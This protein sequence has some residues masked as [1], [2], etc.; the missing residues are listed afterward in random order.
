MR[1]WEQFLDEQE[2]ELGAETV[3]KWLRSLKILRYDARNLYLEAKDSFQIL[4]FEEHMRSKAYAKL[5]TGN[6]SR[7]KV[8][9]SIANAPE[10][11]KKEPKQKKG[12]ND[13][14][15][16]ELLFDTL[17]PHCTFNNFIADE[18][19]K[20]AH[21]LLLEIGTSQKR[22]SKENNA[23]AFNP[24]YL[25][26]HPGSGKTH[27]LMSLA[28]ALSAQGLKIIYTRANTFTDHVVSAIR[29]GQ[30]SQFRQAYRNIDVLIVDDIHVFSRKGATQ[31]EFFHTFNTL[32][33]ENKQIILSS[34]CSPQQLQYIEPRLVSRFEWGIVLP[35][36]SLKKEAMHL[37]LNS[38]AQVLQF[39]LPAHLAEFLV[40]TF[41][42]NSKS[43]IKALEAMVLRLHL[44]SSHQIQ[45]LSIPAV[46][47]L[48][49][50]LILEEQQRA[51]THAIII[52]VVAQ[53]YGIC[54]EDILSKGQRRDC[55]LPRQMAMY[56]CRHQLK[57]PYMKI[58]DIFSRDHSTVMSSIK[59]I[60]KALD[61]NDPEIPHTL[62]SIQK[63]L[64]FR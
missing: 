27:L 64:Q 52:Q 36:K 28:H 30:M 58:G 20:L 57:L 56:L 26:G 49:S 35:I 39:P 2:A 9:L 50:D 10:S 59:Q 45:N 24:I 7:I 43:L 21:Q 14:P 1:A 12:S 22:K 25:Y 32:H 40:E 18:E 3:Q 61:K 53:Q 60:Q 55:V 29:A 4:W 63:K 46:K 15:S 17:D 41:I 47:S 38:K 13:T 33:L 16:F 6:Q 8:H 31:E 34:N 54:P 62:Q 5:L 11:I 23:L 44:D 51:V 37:L 48:L 19:N 42:S